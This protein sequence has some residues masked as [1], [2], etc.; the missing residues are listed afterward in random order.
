MK[1]NSVRK[2]NWKDK[3]MKC[4]KNIQNY[5]AVHVW[6]TKHLSAILMKG[7]LVNLSCQVSCKTI[8]AFL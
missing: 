3:E 7:N 5:H 2:Q 1:M 4:K 8:T 6:I